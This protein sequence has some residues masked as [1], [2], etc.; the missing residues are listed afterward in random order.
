MKLKCENR[1]YGFNSLY[2]GPFSA[3]TMPQN[4]QIYYL[5]FFHTLHPDHS[6]PP[7]SPPS[8]PLLSLLLP[9]PTPPPLLFRKR[10]ASH[11]YQPNI[12][13]QVTVRPD[14]P[15][16]SYTSRKKRVPKTV[17]GSE[18][19]TSPA[20]RSPTGRLGHRTITYIQRA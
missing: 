18:T 3:T 13:Y 8:I 1:M 7:S 5:F 11:R 17:K 16:P 10:Q 4:R 6:Y 14:A 12:A 15:H 20:V 19:A 9:L 2:F